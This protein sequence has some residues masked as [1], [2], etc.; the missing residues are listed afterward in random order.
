MFNIFIGVFLVPNCKSP[1]L[2]RD[3]SAEE[4]VHTAILVN[5]S[6]GLFNEYSRCMENDFAEKETPSSRRGI[7]NCLTDKEG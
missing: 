1:S 5:P 2:G 6:E 4:P 7:G 3:D